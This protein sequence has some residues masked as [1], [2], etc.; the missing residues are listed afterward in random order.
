MS[1][2]DRLPWAQ[3]IDVAPRRGGTTTSSSQRL[4]T[5]SCTGG[6]EPSDA[7]RAIV[8]IARARAPCL[9]VATGDAQRRPPPERDLSRPPRRIRRLCGRA[10][11]L[12]R[13]SAF[14]RL[15]STSTTGLAS[16]LCRPPPSAGATM[17]EPHRART[18]ALLKSHPELRRFIGR[19]PMTALMIGAAVVVQARACSSRLRSQ[20]W[21]AV[22]RRRMALRRIR[23]SRALFVMV[24]RMCARS[25]VQ[26]PLGQ[27]GRLAGR[28]PAAVFSDGGLAS[29]HYHLKHHTHQGVHEL[30]ADLPSEREAQ[31]V[32]NSAPS[33]RHQMWMLLFPA[34]SDCANV[35][36]SREIQFFDAWSHAEL[37]RAAR[38]QRRACG[39][40]LGPKAFVYQACS[41]LL[42]RWGLIRLARG[43]FRSTISPTA[44]RRHTATTARSTPSR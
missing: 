43:G 34:L 3:W 28:Q 10:A 24:R 22:V 1:G 7:V 35:S 19:N 29:R 33:A 32:Q 42:F 4:D 37:G 18:Q 17:R 21:W 6:G 41:A 5:G 31:L 38:V 2:G 15:I 13:G 23:R 44:T 40:L 39:G 26:A 27:R 12:T 30:D 16:G 11:G 20:P 9:R 25:R 36:A 14:E 8:R